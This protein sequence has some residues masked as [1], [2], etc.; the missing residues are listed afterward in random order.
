M[1]GL[2]APLAFEM[3]RRVPSPRTAG[4]ITGMTGYRETARG[5]FS[6][7]EAAPLAVPLIISFGTPFTIALGRDPDATDRQHSFAAGLYAGA[8]HIESDG[9]AECVQVDFTPLGAFRFFG[10]AVVEI[11]RAHV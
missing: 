1:S 7:R 11:G 5:K 9:G 2:G 6:Q 8:V 3:I 4:L 10:G